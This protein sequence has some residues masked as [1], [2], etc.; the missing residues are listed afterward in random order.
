MHT[1]NND[2]V[3][4]LPCETVT[5]YSALTA[6]LASFSASN[7]VTEGSPAGENVSHRIL[8]FLISFLRAENQDNYLSFSSEILRQRKY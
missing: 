7:P 1:G 8:F 3:W 2:A 4:M 5:R 6:S